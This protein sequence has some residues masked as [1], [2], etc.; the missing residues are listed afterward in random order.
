M[1]SINW[2]GLGKLLLLLNGVGLLN[3]I[4]LLQLVATT[5]TM[6]GDNSDDY[7]YLHSGVD[8]D[9]ELVSPTTPPEDYIL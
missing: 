4:G 1:P 8:D 9:A 2:R 5:G 7:A 6:S 3:G